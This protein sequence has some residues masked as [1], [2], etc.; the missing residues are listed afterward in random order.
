MTCT[1]T[2]ALHFVICDISPRLFLLELS[3]LSCGY[4]GRVYA[5]CWASPVPAQCSWASG[6]KHLE[7]RSQPVS[8][9]EARQPGSAGSAARAWEAV[10]GFRRCCTKCTEMA[11]PFLWCFLE[12]I[13]LRVLF[14][15]KE[16][17][18]KPKIH[19]WSVTR[20][21]TLQIIWPFTFCWW[22]TQSAGKAKRTYSNAICLRFRTL[23]FWSHFTT[24]SK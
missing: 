6:D 7:A 12:G 16:K 13:R 22:L 9:R 3:G 1:S 21:T 2:A 10:C 19:F 24:Y 15:N 18:S 8:T 11:L 14:K 5:W 17:Q 23:Q 4:L 20:V